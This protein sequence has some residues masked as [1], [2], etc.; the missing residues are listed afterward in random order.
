MPT[1]KS[2]EGNLEHDALDEYARKHG[3]RVAF[4]GLRL[5]LDD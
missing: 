5:L 3:Y 4:D 1:H 2:H